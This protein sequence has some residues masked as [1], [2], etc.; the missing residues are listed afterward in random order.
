MLIAMPMQNWRLHTSSARCVL[1]RL[2]SGRRKVHTAAYIFWYLSL[3]LCIDRQMSCTMKH[4]VSSKSCCVL[5]SVA[6][7][8]AV[9]A[10]AAF[11]M[12]RTTCE[13][14]MLHHFLT[15]SLSSDLNPQISSIA[16]LAKAILLV[17]RCTVPDV[18][19]VLFLRRCLGRSRCGR[20][21]T[22][23]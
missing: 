2:C 14:D 8:C 10:P 16:N 9:V 7:S 18:G 3:E 12:R 20:R 15:D 1:L 17:C 23:R 22:M 11:A 21:D 6:S 5:S 4:S 19:Y 13:A